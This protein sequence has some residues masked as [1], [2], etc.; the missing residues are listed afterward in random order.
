MIIQLCQKVM[1]CFGLQYRCRFLLVLCILTRSLGS[2]KYCRTRK[3]I[4][5]YCTPKHLITF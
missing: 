1:R 2:S 3:N 4:Q 5:R